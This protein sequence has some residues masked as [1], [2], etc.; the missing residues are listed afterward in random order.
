MIQLKRAY[1]PASKEDGR[2]F[3]VERLW[4]RGVKK[5]LLTVE[6]WLKDVAPSTQLRQWFSH[7]PEK[8]G[9]F[10]RR[11]KAELEQHPEVCDPLLEAARSG[12]VTLVYS[13]HDTEHNNA[14]ALRGYLEARLQRKRKPAGGKPAA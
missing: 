11:Y 6:A 1:E 8:W 10:Q 9:E 5:E 13:S 14:V 12:T 7:D 4:P 3:L 2:R